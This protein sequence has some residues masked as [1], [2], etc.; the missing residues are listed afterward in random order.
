MNPKPPKNIMFDSINVQSVSACSG[1]F[2]GENLQIEWG[3]E[4]KTNTAAG[5]MVGDCNIMAHVV[6]VIYDNDYI[7]SSI[8]VG[9]GGDENW[10]GLGDWDNENNGNNNPSIEKKAARQGPPPTYFF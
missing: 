4:G 9:G 10:N 2:I 3:I 5:S 7:D 8:F 6:N 1:I